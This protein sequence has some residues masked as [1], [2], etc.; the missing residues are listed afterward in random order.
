M[1]LENPDY[2]LNQ[3]LGK[4]AIDIQLDIW[5]IFVYVIVIFQ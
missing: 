1:K 3:R 5:G 4:G 2:R